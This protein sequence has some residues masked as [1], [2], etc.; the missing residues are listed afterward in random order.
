MV[1]VMIL[2]K[3]KASRV[4]KRMYIINTANPQSLA[5]NITAAVCIDGT[6]NL[7]KL[8]SGIEKLVKNNPML[9]ASFLEENSELFYFFNENQE[10]N[11]KVEKCRNRDYITFENYAENEKKEFVK[12]FD[13]KFGPLYRIKI[14]C[15]SENKTIVLVDFHHSIFDGESLRI[16]L[17]KLSNYY[18]TECEIKKDKN[19][20]VQYVDWQEKNIKSE[21]YEKKKEF[22]KEIFSEPSGN[23]GIISDYRI[24]KEFCNQTELLNSIFMKKN[25]IIDFCGQNACTPFSFFA[26]CLNFVMTKLTY[27][28]DIIIGTVASG[29]R[30]EAIKDSFG[31]F[32]NTFPLRN[33]VTNE[34]T[35]KDYIKKIHENNRSA[36][37]NSDVQYEDIMDIVNRGTSNGDTFDVLLR[38]EQSVD[39]FF[40]LDGL[41][42]AAEELLPRS[43]I[44]N[45]VICI[46]EHKESYEIRLNFAKEFYNR[47]TIQLFADLYEKSIQSF[48]YLD[49]GMVKDIDI[50][51]EKEKD[52]VL[53][54]FN[55]KDVD[56][57]I[58]KTVVELF[59]EQVRKTPEYIA[60]VFGEEQLTYQEFNKKVNSLAF[61]LRTEYKMKPGD[62][63]TIIAERSFEMLIGIY[64]IIKAGGAYVPL[65]TGYPTERI[66]F[67]LQD[68]KPKVVLKG[69]G[70]F[71]LPADN[72][73]LDLYEESNYTGKEENPEYVNQSSDLLYM[74]Y[75]SGTTGKPKGTM[76][77]HRNAVN[78]LNHVIR[79]RN[80]NENSI[81][82]QNIYC[83]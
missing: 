65:D 79:S 67:I 62:F 1:N 60:A 73:L 52:R 24:R 35:R 49:N 17:K 39:G 72:V 10:V 2:N 7:D 68:C 56:Y 20:Y 30:I 83:V 29:R 54:I 18:N 22:W 59:E 75:T 43:P 64:A 55:H 76:I 33:N 13:M 66:E 25:G 38:F 44:S 82:L 45:I 32:V 53:N 40:G 36:L 14:A 16:F 8:L 27:H 12:P 50:I 23:N 81:I 19:T 69:K 31:M 15:Y 6:L 42:C 77:E 3:Y 41:R 47:E 28:N 78:L 51:D 26:A 48:L 37:K 71:E 74:I 34:L 11:C 80:L 5:Y 21:E 58:D 57:E 9:N 63:A 4:Q 46:D 61:K 70:E